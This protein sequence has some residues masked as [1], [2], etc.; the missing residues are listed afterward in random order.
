VLSE[1]GYEKT[2][3]RTQGLKVL[4]AGESGTGKTMGAQVI[5]AELGLEIF[6]VD[7]ATTVSK[8]IGETEK[9]L[10]RIFTGA[11]GVNGV[12]FFDEADALFGKRSEVSDAR[13]RY[14]NLEVAY[15]L[16][17]MESFDGLAVLATNLRSNL[18]E[19]FARRISTIVEFPRPDAVQRRLLWTKSL[20]AVP[21]AGDVDLDFCASAFDV[22]GGDI[23]NIAVTAAYLAAAEDGILDMRRLMRSVRLEY[24]KLGRLCVEAEFGRYFPLLANT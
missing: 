1:W 11:D 8:Y 9:N 13:D 10:E 16:Q 7:L 5:A 24:R 2:V 23:R 20:A 19:A 21:L 18:D 3:S 12:L 14:A 15:L 4:F 17:R 22:A 6:R